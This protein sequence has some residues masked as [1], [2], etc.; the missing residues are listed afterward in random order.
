MEKW[1]ADRP[2]HAGEA[3]KQWLKDLYQDNKLIKSELELGGRKVD[4]QQHHHAG[5]EHLRQGRSHHPAA[6]RR[7]HSRARSAPTTTPSSACPAGISACSS[8]ASRRASS[9]RGSSTGS[10]SATA[11]AGAWPV[12]NKI[13]WRPRRSR[14]I[15]DGRHGRLLGLCRH[16]HAR[17]S[18]MALE[19][20]F[21]DTA[22][23]ARLT[24][25][26]AA[27]PGDGK[28]R[29]LNRLARRRAGQAR[30]RRALGAGAEARRDGGSTARSRPTTCRWAASRSCSATSPARRPGHADRR[31]GSRTFVDP[32]QRRRQAQRPHHRG[33]GASDA[34]RC[35]ARNG[36]ST[37]P[38]RSTSRSCA[39]PPPTPAATSPWSARR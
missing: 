12:R 22:S 31:S 11:R 23:A 25:L 30:G 6:R 36:C 27:A 8:A 10:P 28:E 32:R 19:K 16:R 37:R 9:A 5:A 21:L 20:R 24:L 15:R 1:L 29:G 33:S 4:L 38:S 14:I 26:F 35:A 3:A 13:V 39:A 17:R 18:I 7:G 2:H 34:D